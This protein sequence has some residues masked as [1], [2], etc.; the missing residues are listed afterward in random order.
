MSAPEAS[1]DSRRR[2]LLMVLFWVGVGLAPLAALLL[3]LGQGGGPLRI[4]VVLAVLA[5]VLIGISI[6]LRGDAETVRLDMEE[7]LLDEIDTLREDL[8]NDIATAARATHRAFGEKLQVVQDNVEALRGQIQAGRVETHRGGQERTSYGGGG[9]DRGGYDQ[10][11][12]AAPPSTAPNPAT[13]QSAPVG[14]YAAASGPQGMVGGHQQ[15]APAPTG[16]RAGVPPAGAIPMQR[17]PVSGGLVRHTE[18]VQV[19]TRHTV[20][21]PHAEAHGAGN[22]YGS[23]VYGGHAAEPPGGG[24]GEWATPSPQRGRRAAEDDEDP[25]GDQLRPEPRGGDGRRSR[26]YDDDG[27]AD[28]ER[29]SGMRAGDRWASVRSDER[30]REVRV[31]ERRAA[32][33][34]DESGA[35]M[36][37]EDRWA[38][39]RREEP[40]REAGWRDGGGRDDGWGDGPGSRDGGRDPRDD[41][42][43]DGGWGRRGGQAALPAGGIEQPASWGGQDWVEPEREPV[44]RGRRSRDDEVYGYPPPDDAPRAGRGPRMDYEYSDDRWR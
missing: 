12:P 13:A 30:G 42:A 38:A 39:V 41:A 15:P 3:L 1:A 9:Y 16:G 17:P 19:T 24:R 27:P 44:R 25:W 29:W 32:V 18:T 6:T 7:A 14:H 22:V 26:S 34:A 37:I 8:R 33:H 31:G 35:E 43:G 11:A 23:G 36:R 5:V 28:D 4:A 2:S 21:D 10:S 20:V 40:R